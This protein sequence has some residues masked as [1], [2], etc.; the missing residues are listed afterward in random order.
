MK[1]GVIR[2][3]VRK[4]GRA[5]RSS[6]RGETHAAIVWITRRITYRRRKPATTPQHVAVHARPRGSASPRPSGAEG[7]KRSRPRRAQRAPHLGLANPSPRLS[8]RGGHCCRSSYRA[9]CVAAGTSAPSFSGAGSSRRQA[10][11]ATAA[12]TVAMRMAPFIVSLLMLAWAEPMVS[13]LAQRSACRRRAS[14]ERALHDG[15]RQEQQQ[16]RRRR[17]RLHSS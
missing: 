8:S 14:A 12:T 10:P 4:C 6:W 2:P 13:E 3:F 5:P 9:G 7:P 1:S 16:Q 17:V 11:R 15:K